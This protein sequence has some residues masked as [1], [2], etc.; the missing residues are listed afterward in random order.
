[1]G[2][3]WQGWTMV[4]LHPHQY[5]Y[6][7]SIIGG[8]A[9][10]QGKYEVEYWATSLR[11]TTLKLADILAKTEGPPAEPFKVWVSYNFV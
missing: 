6:F 3:L 11:E 5:V 4:R 8:P 7:N 10:A 2:V 9:G 1:M